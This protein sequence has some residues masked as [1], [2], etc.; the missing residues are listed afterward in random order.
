M[1]KIDTS[2][3]LPPLC[4]FMQYWRYSCI[5]HSV[6]VRIFFWLSKIWHVAFFRKID[7]GNFRRNYRMFP[8]KTQ[9]DHNEV[10]LQFILQLSFMWFFFISASQLSHN[11]H[12]PVCSQIFTLCVGT[13]RKSLCKANFWS[14]SFLIF[15]YTG[16]YWKAF[17]PSRRFIRHF[18]NNSSVG[19]SR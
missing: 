13:W 7:K 19:T 8:R 14:S 11:L 4:G 1:L 5:K 12:G 15:F 6:Y 9:R 18:W 2:F 16:M 17:L 3:N 10:T